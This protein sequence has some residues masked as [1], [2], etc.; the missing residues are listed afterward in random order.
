MI[1]STKKTNKK[2][3]LLIQRGKL[4]FEEAGGR[5]IKITTEKRLRPDFIDVSFLS[6]SFFLVF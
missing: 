2:K 1:S 5:V 3:Q 4:F 6:D